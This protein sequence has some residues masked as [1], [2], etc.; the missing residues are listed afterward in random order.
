MGELIGLCVSGFG[1]NDDQS[2]A[3]ETSQT[4]HLKL[5]KASFD[6]KAIKTNGTAR[7]TGRILTCTQGM[8]EQKEIKECQRNLKKGE[9]GCFHHLKCFVGL[10]AF[11]RKK[12]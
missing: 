10:E 1:C 12:Y 11:W 7:D 3:P 8:A 6:L 9:T 2:S 4:T 5:E